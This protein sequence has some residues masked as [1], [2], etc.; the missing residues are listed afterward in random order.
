LEDTHLTGSDQLR[1]LLMQATTTSQLG[2]PAA[3]AVDLIYRILFTEGEANVARLAD[4]TR[5]FPQ[6]IDE[7]MADLQHDHMVEV[8]KAGALRLSYTYRLTDEGTNRARDALERTQYIGPFPVDIDS[9]RQA[10]VLQTNEQQKVAPAD[11]KR[12]LSSL[13]LPENFHRR[14]GPAINSGSSLFLYGPPGNGKTTVAQA[15]AKLLAGANPVWLPYA[16]SIGGQIVQIHDPLVHIPFRS[17]ESDTPTGKTG[18]IGVDKR[19][20]LFQRPSVMVGGELTMDA[21]ELRF[22]PVTKIYEAP[23][24]MKANCG[25]FLIDDFG[26]QPM[27]PQQLLNRWIVPLETRIDYL[28]MQSGQTLE[29]PFRQLIVFATNLD[30]AALVDA[31]FLRRIQMKVEV[32]SP[33]EKMFYQVF[34]VMC[35]TLK[36]A[37]DRNGFVHLLQ[38]WYRES[39]RTM[40]SVHPR[41]ILKTLIAICD[42]AGIPPQMTPEL[43]DEACSCYFVDTQTPQ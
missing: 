36:V 34:T 37:F 23:L 27:S 9:Y 15:I 12:A 39:G 25:M 38:K 24:Q 43:L 13:I 18:F 21:L 14:I 41:D 28:R 10:V 30:P 4:I 16:I 8:V 17:P 5:L 19:W 33:D 2:L 31:A 7:I 42:Y 22:E 3:L 20:G 32:G 1:K 35:Q 40:Q 6:V 29:V 26:R 11:V